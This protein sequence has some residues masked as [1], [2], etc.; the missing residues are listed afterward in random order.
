MGSNCERREEKENSGVENI[1][2]WTDK[3]TEKL[4]ISSEKRGTSSEK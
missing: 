4:G 2:G 1:G 3:S